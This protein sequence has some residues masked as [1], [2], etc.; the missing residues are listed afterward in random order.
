VAALCNVSADVN[1]QQHAD[2]V[3]L[4][5]GKHGRLVDTLYLKGSQATGNGLGYPTLKLRE[6]PP[7]LQLS[8]Y[9]T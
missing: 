8:S 5:L 9:P 4:Y 1:H 2:A 6:L 7:N 3:L